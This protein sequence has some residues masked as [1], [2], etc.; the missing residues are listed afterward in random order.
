[1]WLSLGKLATVLLIHPFFPMILGG[2]STNWHPVAQ[3]GPPE[4]SVSQTSDFGRL[5]ERMVREQLQ[6]RDITDAINTSVNPKVI[7]VPNS[8]GLLA[9]QPHRQSRVPAASPFRAS[10]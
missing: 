7:D 8:V 9:Q 2:C 5:R 3:K 4:T 1:M 6:G 10:Q